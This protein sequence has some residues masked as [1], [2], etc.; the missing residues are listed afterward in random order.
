MTRGNYL[1]DEYHISILKTICTQIKDAL[2]VCLIKVIFVVVVI[3]FR[4]IFFLQA[5]L[6]RPL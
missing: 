1:A 2:L 4:I 3:L 6:H 5:F